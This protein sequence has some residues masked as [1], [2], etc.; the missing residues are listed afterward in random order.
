MPFNKLFRSAEKTSDGLSQS[1]REAIVDLLHFCMYADGHIALRE[2]EFIEATA[3]TL[4]WDVCVSY[5]YYEGKSTGAVRTA[6]AD[7]ESKAA[8]L[9]SLKQR[10]PGQAERSLAYKLAQDLVKSDGAQTERES[11]VLLEIKST[12]GV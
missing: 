7:Q 3:R 6:L 8:F 2:D 5:E 4:D 1:A 12:L 10:L 9:E 11:S